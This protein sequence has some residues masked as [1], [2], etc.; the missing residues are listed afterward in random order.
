MFERKKQQLTEI[1]NY[2]Q[3][4]NNRTNNRKILYNFK[5][6]GII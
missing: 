3:P 1:K 5:S 6:N 2:K 4:K